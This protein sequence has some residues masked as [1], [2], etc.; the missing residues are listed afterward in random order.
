MLY[1]ATLEVLFL[2]FASRAGCTSTNRQIL[3]SI[4]N[5]LEMNNERTGAPP[6]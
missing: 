1:V 6:T 2:L 5:Q 3:E 4:E